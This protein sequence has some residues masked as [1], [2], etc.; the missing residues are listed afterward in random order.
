ML[1]S[2]SLYGIDVIIAS[3]II[4]KMI[5]IW[6]VVVNIINLRFYDTSSW[7]VVELICD[8]LYGPNLTIV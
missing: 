1:S 3:Y 2:Y 4:H 8:K 5:I 7:Q 6:N